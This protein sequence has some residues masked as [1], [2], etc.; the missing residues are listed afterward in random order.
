MVGRFYVALLG[1]VGSLD[2]F[3]SEFVDTPLAWLGW[4][5]RWVC[6]C[7]VAGPGL[8]LKLGKEVGAVVGGWVGLGC[9]V[10]G[11]AK[12]RARVWVRAY[13]CVCVCV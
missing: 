3:Q 10:R 5:K 11:R 1:F 6:D 4:D 12:V 8:Q 7:W 13:V 9:W 2:A